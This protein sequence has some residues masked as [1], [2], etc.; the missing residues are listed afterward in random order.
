[1]AIWRLAAALARVGRVELAGVAGRR[2]GSL[3][4]VAVPPHAA[5]AAAGRAGPADG[6]A[7]R[8]RVAGPV[9][10]GEPGA[11][12]TPPARTLGARHARGG[13]GPLRQHDLRRPSRRDPAGQRDA[14][15]EAAR[16]RG[17]QG[18]PARGLPPFRGD[19]RDGFQPGRRP[20]GERAGHGNPSLRF[21]PPDARTHAGGHRLPHRWVGHHGRQRRSCWRPKRSGAA[22]RCIS[23]SARTARWPAS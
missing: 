4:R 5:R 20:P 18:V 8:H 7:R 2:G 10:P 3:H 1:M 13:G 9:V 11:R 22:C 17:R 15:L 19:L 6:L 12:R 23:P 21:A 14:A 16:S